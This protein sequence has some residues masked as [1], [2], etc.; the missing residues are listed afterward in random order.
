[1]R[2]HLCL[3][4]RD[5][6]GD[7]PAARE[8]I[9]CWYLEPDDLG[10]SAASAAFHTRLRRDRDD[11]RTSPQQWQDTLDKLRELVVSRGMGQ[12]GEDLYHR[13][14][15]AW[16]GALLLDE[17]TMIADL[18]DPFD[19]RPL[20]LPLGDALT[21]LDMIAL[22]AL[23]ENWPQVRD[24]FGDDALDRFGDDRLSA[25]HARP[26]HAAA[27]ERLALI[28]DRQ[29]LLSAQLEAAV[30]EH[31]QLLE[32]DAVISWYA[33]THRGQPPLLDVLIERVDADSSNARSLASM[34]LAEPSSLGIE[35]ED[36]RARLREHLAQ[37]GVRRPGMYQSGAL[38]A[39]AEGF[40]DDEFVH[41]CWQ[42]V[43]DL[44]Q[45]HGR[46]G[47][48]P[49]TYLPLAYAAV[50]ASDLRAQMAKDT[51]LLHLGEDGYFDHQFTR[52]I[53]QR[54]R[55]D[56]QARTRMEEE[57]RDPQLSD[58]EAAQL[59]GFL[60]AAQTLSPETAENLA[61][62]LAAHLARAAQQPTL[63]YTPLGGESVA[64]ALLSV[65]DAA[66]LE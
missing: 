21:G 31:P 11:G 2:R 24:V 18:S 50:P 60:A 20:R 28:A 59:A 43:C 9:A 45:R 7:G 51:V 56:E 49:R 61:G 27:W 66:V 1:V 30:T 8:I 47:M 25:A 54:L 40:P 53:V 42:N 15:A 14:I 32:H 17:L 22:G 37:A 58:G 29:P 63:E 44:R 34:L 65:L 55:R 41:A 52:A 23:A 26:G 64:V 46:A 57:V 6:A 3:L 13:R 33:S 48:H 4:L 5:A 62:R 19:G 38:E 16:L 12:R 36:V 39:L 10:R 35:A